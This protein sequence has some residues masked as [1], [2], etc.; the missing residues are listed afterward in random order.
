M[1]CADRDSRLKSNT[2]S[3]K[4]RQSA[5]KYRFLHLELGDSKTQEATDGVTAFKYGDVVAGS[6]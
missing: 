4:L 3:D 5:I 1:L 2:F 6:T